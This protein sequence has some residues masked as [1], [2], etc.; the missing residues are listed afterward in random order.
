ME[1]RQSRG[2]V[3]RRVR[4]MTPMRI[5]LDIT[6][7][8]L[9]QHTA[10]DVT[11][12]ENLALEVDLAL[13]LRVDP[14]PAQREECVEHERRVLDV[15]RADAIRVVMRHHLKDLRNREGVKHEYG[16]RP[17]QR[18]E[19]GRGKERQRTLGCLPSQTGSQM[20]ACSCQ[21]L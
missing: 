13:C 8:L 14:R 3:S 6:T 16:Q 7:E 2:M 9:E 19:R 17:E 4:L 15:R 20:D 1:E 21:R 11:E 18:L 10:V 12:F 5:Y